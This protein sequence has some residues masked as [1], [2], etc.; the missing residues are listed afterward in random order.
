MDDRWK[1]CREALFVLVSHL[2]P[3]SENGAAFL[4]ESLLPALNAHSEASS[5]VIGVHMSGGEGESEEEGDQSEEEGAD[6]HAHELQTSGD[7]CAAHHR[8]QRRTSA[9]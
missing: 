6:E 9:L 7:V 4:S 3:Q 1:R 8:T 5:Y 2:D